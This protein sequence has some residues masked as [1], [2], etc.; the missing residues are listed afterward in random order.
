MSDDIMRYRGVPF[1]D[2][3]PATLATNGRDDP[4]AGIMYC[5][6]SRMPINLLHDAIIASVRARAR[7]SRDRDPPIDRKSM[8]PFGMLAR[9]AR[10]FWL[11]VIAVCVLIDLY[12]VLYQGTTSPAA[13]RSQP[14]PQSESPPMQRTTA[15]NES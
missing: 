11:A 12:L 7:A 9:P 15:R 8:A 4:H 10:T 5:T 2:A 1:R 14:Q 13:T 3:T 6:E